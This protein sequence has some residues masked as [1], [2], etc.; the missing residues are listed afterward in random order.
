MTLY[1]NSYADF[2]SALLLIVVA[3]IILRKRDY[4][5]LRE[6]AFFGLVLLSISVLIVEGISFIV[7]GNLW[8]GAIAMNYVTNYYLYL[9]T[10]IV[11]VL[12][13]LYVDLTITSS[14]EHVKKVR[15]YSVFLVVSVLPILVNP[16]TDIIFY[17]N[18]DNVFMRGPYYWI[19]ALA[20]YGLF[21]YLLVLVIKH[22]K[23]VEYYVYLSILTLV[24]LPA[25]GGILQVLFLGIASIHTTLALGQMTV[26][27]SIETANA[28]RDS[29]TNLLT[30]RKALDYIQANLRNKTPFTAIMVDMDNLKDINDEYGHHEGDHALIDL[31]NALRNQCEK[32]HVIARVGGDEFLIVTGEMQSDDIDQ[33]LIGLRD[34]LNQDR[35]IQIKFS[36]GYYTMR[37]DTEMTVDDILI[38][39]DERMY[40]QKSINKNWRRRKSDRMV[41]K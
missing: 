22:R 41:Q 35:D 33:R 29:M 15:Y 1:L 37:H 23:N 9:A 18:D 30:R 32:H 31:A 25:A 39:I 27:M 40:I 28:S 2:Y 14:E 4:Y 10:P 38:T 17:I 24:I 6:R 34:N 11:G 19:S 16:F 36:W 12:W 26:Y 7:D 20:F 3:A 21:V 5:T 13:A 8:T